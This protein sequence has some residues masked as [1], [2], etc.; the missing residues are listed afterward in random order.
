MNEENK[1]QKKEIEENEKSQ[2]PFVI[3]IGGVSEAME[4]Y[5]F[6]TTF[7]SDFTIAE[8]FGPEAIIDTFNRAFNEWKSDYIYLT[9]LVL[10]LNWKL[11]TFYES[12]R[13]DL[14]ALYDKLWKE[15]DSY[16]YDNLKGEELSYFLNTTD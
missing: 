11:W 15:A 1:N 8:S 13:Q 9:E 16:A 14:A 4:G 5:N 2:E 10:V 12:G 7:W 3:Q 6:Q